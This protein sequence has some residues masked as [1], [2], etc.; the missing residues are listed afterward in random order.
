MFVLHF[1]NTLSSSY[2]SIPNLEL[3]YLEIKLFHVTDII[4]FI[5]EMDRC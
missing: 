2:T 4:R 1:L 3:K 5:L